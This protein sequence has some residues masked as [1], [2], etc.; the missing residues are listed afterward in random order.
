MCAISLT[1][2]KNKTITFNGNKRVTIVKNP[3]GK[4]GFHYDPIFKPIKSKKTYGQMTAK[5]KN[6]V[7]HRSI[8]LKKLVKYLKN[9]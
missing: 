4:K 6:L 2:N 3:K 7:S 8:A 1:I 9:N 5:E